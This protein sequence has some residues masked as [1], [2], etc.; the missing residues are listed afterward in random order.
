MNRVVSIRHWACALV[1]ASVACTG[2][3]QSATVYKCPGPPMLYTDAL[4]AKEAK[5]KG[6]SPLEG[7][8]ITIVPSAKPRAPS[9]APSPGSTAVRID[10]ADQRARDTDRRTI[11]GAELR[12]E[13]EALAG[14]KKE[15]NNGEPD[16][17]GSERNYQKY[18]DRV[19]ELKASIARKESDVAAL[20]R[21]ISKLPADKAAPN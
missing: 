19:A 10:P 1:V 5:D 9:A 2:W 21:E 18:L 16:R 12:K 20:K 15:Y 4:S 14:L 11:L 13:E 7:T 17:L 8:P 3:A 6:C